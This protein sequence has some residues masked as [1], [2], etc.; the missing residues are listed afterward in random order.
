MYNNSIIAVNYKVETITNLSVLI[1][2]PEVH[3]K[4]QCVPH[5]HAI[6]IFAVTDYVKPL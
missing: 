5:I 4:Q 3:D 1:V 6:S 2:N